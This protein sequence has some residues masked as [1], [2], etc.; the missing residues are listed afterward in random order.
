MRWPK[1]GRRLSQNYYLAKRRAGVPEGLQES[2]C[3]VPLS[4]LLL[5]A[6]RSALLEQAPRAEVRGGTRVSIRPMMP[7]L[8]A[9]HGKISPMQRNDW[10]SPLRARGRTTGSRGVCRGWREDVANLRI[11]SLLSNPLLTYQV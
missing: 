6:A 5:V 8:G 3:V 1:A 4:A 9:E 2:R 11:K 10:S 7:L